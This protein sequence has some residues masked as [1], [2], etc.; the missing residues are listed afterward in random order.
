MY[1][2]VC[3]YVCM[4]VCGEVWQISGL[5]ALTEQSSLGLLAL[6]GCHGLG[7]LGSITMLRHNNLETKTSVYQ[8]DWS[9][10]EDTLRQWGFFYRLE[11][12]KFLK[13]R[14]Q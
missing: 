7:Q 4:R 8:T 5:G 10:E 2:Y 6:G 9:L 13:I 3:V 14:R 1:V 11:N 12:K